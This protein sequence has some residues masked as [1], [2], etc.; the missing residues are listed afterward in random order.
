MVKTARMKISSQIFWPGHERTWNVEY[1]LAG[2]I[3]AAL[4][5]SM[6]VSLADLPPV[7][8]FR[9]YIAAIHHGKPAR[10]IVSVK[11]QEMNVPF[12]LGLQK[13]LEAGNCGAAVTVSRPEMDKP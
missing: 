6:A 1:L 5:A 9:K 7:N 10:K 2:S 8:F 3:P 11:Q 13:L 12:R 4:A